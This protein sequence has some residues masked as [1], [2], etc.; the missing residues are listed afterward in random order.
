MSC[1]RITYTNTC[2]EHS[3]C[4]FCIVATAPGVSLSHPHLVSRRIAA[5]AR[6]THLSSIHSAQG[7]FLMGLHL[8]EIV[9]DVLSD[10]F[11]VDPEVKNNAQIAQLLEQ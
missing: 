7:Q 8:P 10:A 11:N 3:A 9:T 2:T 6:G 1:I 4:E 5:G